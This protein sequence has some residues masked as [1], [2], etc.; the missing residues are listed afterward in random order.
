MSPMTLSPPPV[1]AEHTNQQSESHTLMN[2]SGLMLRAVVDFRE[3]STTGT[4]PAGLAF[5]QHGYGGCADQPYIKALADQYVAQ[6]FIAVRIDGAN[7]I[8]DCGG[9]LTDM[10]IEGHCHDLLDVIEWAKAQCWYT[11]PF[12]LAGH[13]MGGFSALHAASRNELSGKVLHVIASA[14]VTDGAMCVADWERNHADSVN[15]WCANG[16]IKETSAI[17]P[18]RTEDS[19]PYERWQSWR[20]VSLLPRA[21]ALTMPVAF[22]SGDADTLTTPAQIH[23]LFE[24]IATAKRQIL[25]NGAD[26]CYTGME[27]QAK[28]AFGEALAWVL[29]PTPVIPDPS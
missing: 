11:E 3:D 19:I 8:N 26:H 5:I 15:E 13:S 24:L 16:F 27:E 12:A 10:T 7:T 4:K 22:I 23:A 29:Q 28:Q 2:R 18:D 20:S 1:V 21:W 14:P 9:R 17:Y 6:G 25:L